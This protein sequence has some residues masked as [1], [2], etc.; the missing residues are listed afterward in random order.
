MLPRI[1]NP[2][3]QGAYGRQGKQKIKQKEE[4]ILQK[5]KEIELDP[6][7]SKAKRLLWDNLKRKQ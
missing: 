1:D 4:E 5:A 2:I 3:I 7:R 6:Q